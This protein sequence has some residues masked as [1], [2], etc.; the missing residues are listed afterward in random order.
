MMILKE[1]WRWFGPNDPVSLQDV[2]QTGAAGIVT[3]LHHIPHGE[4]WPVEEINERKR[5]IEDAG[6]T[7]DVVESVTIHESIKTRTGNYQHY[8]DLYKQSLRNL[9]A[10]GIKIV[11]YNFMPVNDWTRTSLDFLMPD[12][13]KALYFNWFDLAVFDI[14]ILKR[15]GAGQSY[16]AAVLLEAEKRFS[17][18]SSRDLQQ[19][20]DVVMFGIP[21]EQQQTTGLMLEKLASYKDIDR[22]VLRENL[23][24]FLEE[25][26]PVTDEAGIKMALHPD[27][28]PFDIL[29]LPRIVSTGEDIEFIL[30]AVPN[31]SN[32]ICF[33]TGSLGANSQNDLVEIARKAGTRIHFVHLRNTKRDE[34]GNFYEADHLGGD[35]D[36]YSVVKEILHIQ[37]TLPQP[38]PFRPDH[39]HQMMDDLNKVTN[40]GY[41]CIG[42]MRGLSEIRGLQLGISRSVA[43][44]LEKNK[45]YAAEK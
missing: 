26:T 44:E 35:T 34:F 12:G 45:L 8:I 36:M 9:A 28:P 38:I 30:K 37:Q 17:N 19:L 33:C 31:K 3:A 2:K 7:W 1:T 13:S 27:D 24:Y 20:A 25:I 5:I 40:P 41:S 15:P 22:T 10:C 42:R 14:Y 32:G 39:G 16:E 18:Y 4:V 23:K 43:L 6:L 29:G 21:G 11:T